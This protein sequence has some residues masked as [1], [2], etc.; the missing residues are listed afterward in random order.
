VK[1]LPNCSSMTGPELDACIQTYSAHDVHHAA[2]QASNQAWPIVKGNFAHWLSAVLTWTPIVDG[3]EVKEQ[4]AQAFAAGRQQKVP[5]LIGSNANEG[6]TFIYDK[7]FPAISGLEF[8]VALPL[9]FGAAGGAKVSERYH[10]PNFKSAREAISRMITDFWFRCS[11]ESLALAQTSAG[12]TSYVYRFNHAPSFKSLWP[13]FGLPTACEDK[14]CHMAEIPFVYNNY[15][16]YTSEVTPTELVLARSLGQYWTSFVRAGAP[17][18]SAGSVAWPPVDKT[19]LNFVLDTG[20]AQQPNITIES[21]AELC[22]FWDS[23]GYVHNEASGH[24]TTA[25]AFHV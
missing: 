25:F 3:D 24:E 18:S 16:N 9:I 2:D 22:E 1:N 6:A 14:V 10:A 7:S 13:Q 8:K 4:P 21:A 17:S 12:S 19:R 11:S 5:I 15:A 23:I 20:S